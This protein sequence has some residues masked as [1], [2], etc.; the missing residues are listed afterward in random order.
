MNQPIQKINQDGDS[1]VVISQAKFNRAF[2]KFC[3]R[4]QIDPRE[5]NHRQVG[6]PSKRRKEANE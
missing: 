6:R 3:E 1:P 5:F 4:H 2:L